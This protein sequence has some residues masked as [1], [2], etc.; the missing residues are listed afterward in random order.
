MFSSGVDFWSPWEWDSWSQWW[1][2]VHG[3][4]QQG[5]RIVC[6]F[7]IQS[8]FFSRLS[9]GVSSV[10]SR[11]WSGWRRIPKLKR[12]ILHPRLSWIEFTCLTTLLWIDQ[13]QLLHCLHTQVTH[14]PMPNIKKISCGPN[15]TV[16]VDENNKVDAKIQSPSIQIQTWYASA[17][18]QLGLW[19]VRKA[20][21]FWDC[22]WAGQKILL[23]Y[24]SFSTK[25]MF[26]FVMLILKGATADQVLGWKEQGREGSNL[27]LRIQSWNLWD[28]GDGEHV[29]HLHDQ[30]R[31][32]HVPQANPRP[33]WLECAQHCLQH[34][35]KFLCHY[36]L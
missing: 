27:R 9:L 6:W 36:K 34:Q 20:W 23:I 24:F 11:W 15:H 30:Q 10:P 7:F 5:L 21:T 19:W 2:Q 14:L 1:W 22:R 28:P 25:S 8:L 17:G 3:Q 12:W 33:L 13:S 31:G 4:S 26:G 29:G 16:A 32:E 18:F 35:G